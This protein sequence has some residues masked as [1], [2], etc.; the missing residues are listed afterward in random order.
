LYVYLTNNP[1]TTAG[2]LE[3]GKVTVFEGTHIYTIEG[4]IPLNQYN[5]LLYFCKPFNVKVGDGEIG[6]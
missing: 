1:S 4:D 6:E 2:A 3:I 5:Y